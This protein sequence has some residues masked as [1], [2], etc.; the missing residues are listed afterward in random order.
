MMP[1]LPRKVVTTGTPR[2]VSLGMKPRVLLKDGDVV[3]P[4]VDGLGKPRQIVTASDA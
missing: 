4:G 1:L 3:E 2:S